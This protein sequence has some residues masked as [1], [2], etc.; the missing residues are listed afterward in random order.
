MSIFPRKNTVKDLQTVSEQDIRRIPVESV[1]LQLQGQGVLSAASSWDVLTSHKADQMHLCV[2]RECCCC[3]RRL[4]G[5]H[6]RNLDKILAD[7]EDRSKAGRGS[8]W[9]KLHYFCR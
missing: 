8:Y 9:S 4:S 1:L 6:T 5:T 3:S 7:A 2:A